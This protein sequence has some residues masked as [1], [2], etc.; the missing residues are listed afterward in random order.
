MN[1]YSTILW[2]LWLERNCRIFGGVERSL[3]EVWEVVRFDVHLYE[4]LLTE[5]FVFINMVLFF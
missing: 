3:K 5:F 4:R 2:G 1:Y